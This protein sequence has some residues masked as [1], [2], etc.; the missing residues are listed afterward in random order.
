MY[1][2]NKLFIHLLIQIS[3]HLLT[4]AIDGQ[5]AIDELV[6]KTWL[7]KWQERHVHRSNANR[8]VS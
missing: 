3:K 6:T 5:G 8:K 4:I 7:P 1:S 2:C